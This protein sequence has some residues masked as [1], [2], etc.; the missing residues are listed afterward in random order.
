MIISVEPE[1]TFDKIQYPFLIK[2]FN[3]LKIEENIFNLSMGIYEKCTA[4]ITIMKDLNTPPP[5]PPQDQE[6][7]KYVCSHQLLF[8]IIKTSTIRQ[9]K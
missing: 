3:K 9:E 8:S 2:I 6:Q 4:N 1:K 7:G 5:T